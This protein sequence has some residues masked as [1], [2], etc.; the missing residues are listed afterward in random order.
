[1]SGPWA[2]ET[3]N[4]EHALSSDPASCTLCGAGPVAVV[5]LFGPAEPWRYCADPPGADRLRAIVYGLCAGC[6]GPGAP[7]AVEAELLARME[8]HPRG[9]RGGAGHAL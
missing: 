7:E 3:A 1:M 5:G 9:R 8:G 6:S 2:V 4:G